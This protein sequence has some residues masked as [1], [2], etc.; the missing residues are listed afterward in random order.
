MRVP[1]LRLILIAILILQLSTHIK[2][3]SS[4]FSYPPSN[5]DTEYI[6]T[7]CNVTLYPRLCYRTL[8]FY[9]SDIKADPKLLANTALNV[10]LISTKS[11]ARLAR[12]MSRL[13]GSG[14]RETAAL[15]DCVEVVGDSVYELQRSMEE[16]NEL[17]GYDFER[18]LSDIQTW[19]SAALTDD[20]TCMDGVNEQ[21]GNGYVKTIVRKHILRIAHLTSN[22]LAIINSFASSVDANFH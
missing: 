13:L 15:K 1:F 2:S 22:A 17:K 7:S 8:S 4:T 14:P 21:V 10:S 12:K 3:I 16:M 18:L 11:T 6:K 19:V 20:E 9:A 5:T